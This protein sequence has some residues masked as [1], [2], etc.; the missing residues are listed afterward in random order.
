MVEIREYPDSTKP[1]HLNKL[2]ELPVELV[3][4]QSFGALSKAESLSAMARQKKWLEDSK[5]YSSSQIDGLT[6]ALNELASGTFIMG[7]HHATITVFGEDS[8][9]TPPRRPRFGVSLVGAVT[10]QLEVAPASC[11]HHVVELPVLLVDA[12]LPLRQAQWQPMGAC[13]HD[14]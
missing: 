12:Q 8:S 4:S 1:G 9:K 13:C 7:D 5:D 2:L 6:K 11:P 3:V 10:L 14:A